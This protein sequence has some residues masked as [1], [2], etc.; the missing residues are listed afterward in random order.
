MDCSLPGSSVHGI[1]QVRV[2]EWVAIAFSNAWKGKGKVKSLSHVQLSATPWTTAYQAPP[3][4]GFSRQEYWSGL[5]LPSPESKFNPLLIW[6]PKAFA[7][8]IIPSF[9]HHLFSPHYWIMPLAVI[10]L[11]LNLPLLIPIASQLIFHFSIP[12]HSLT[13]RKTCYHH[14]PFF[15]ETIH[16]GFYL[17][18]SIV[19]VTNHSHV[20]KIKSIIRLNVSLTFDTADYSLFL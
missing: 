8:E 3:S 13:S 2:L 4:M 1:F 16:S 7:A 11:V 14:F 18:H 20:A 15:H 9:L 12:L 17:Q 6:P 5:P 10:Y 19:K